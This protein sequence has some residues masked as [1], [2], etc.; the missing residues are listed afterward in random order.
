M[1]NNEYLQEPSLFAMTSL[2]E[3]GTANLERIDLIWPPITSHF[4]EVCSSSEA[5]LRGFAADS[6]SSLIRSALPLAKNKEVYIQLLSP[7]LS[8]QS[9]LHVDVRQ[10]QLD[11]VSN[12]LHSSGQSLGSSWDV[13]LNVI[14]SA[15]S[16]GRWGQKVKSQ[17]FPSILPPVVAK[18]ALFGIPPVE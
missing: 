10:R 17:T 2:L 11:C 3:T 16:L 14:K 15:A 12:V 6:L 8:L 5:T 4:I 18:C 7:L 1:H 9:V 13:I